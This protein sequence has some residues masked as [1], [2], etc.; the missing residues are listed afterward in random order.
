MVE[1]VIAMQG[2][3]RGGAIFASHHLFATYDMRFTGGDEVPG[4]TLSG[5]AFMPLERPMS[6]AR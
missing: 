2:M 1:G 4:R 5:A 3:W 6:F